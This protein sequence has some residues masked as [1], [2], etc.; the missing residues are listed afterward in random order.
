MIKKNVIHCLNHA[1]F[2]GSTGKQTHSGF[3]KVLEILLRASP[4]IISLCPG[5]SDSLSAANSTLMSASLCFLEAHWTKTTT[6][7]KKQIN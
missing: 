7:T 2:F 6:T 1:L 5:D 4:L 3:L